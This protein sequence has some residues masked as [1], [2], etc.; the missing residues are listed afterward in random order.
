MFKRLL[1][2]NRGE[3]ACRIIKTAKK[4][5]ITT[6]AIYSDVDSKSLYVTEADEAFHIGPAPAID[7]YLNIN[8]IITLAKNI[9][10]DAIHPGYGF[11]SENAEFAKACEDANIIFVGP[12]SKNIHDMGLKNEAK[13]LAAKYG[14]PVLSDDKTFPLLIKPVAG[15]GGKGMR[16]VWQEKDFAE[17]L[18]SA[19]RE[20]LN[21]FGNDEV[22]I[23][24]YL[25]QPRHIE[26]QV[27]ADKHQNAV[28]LFER[29]CSLQ[30]RYQ[31]VIEQAPA[32]QLSQSLREKMGEAA[33]NIVRGINYIGLGTFEFLLDGNEKFYFMEMNT[34][35][36]VEHGVTELITGIDLVEQQLYVAAGEKLSLKQNDLKMS[37]VAIEARIYAEDPSEDFLPSTGEILYLEYPENVRFDNGIK[38][39]DKITIYYD[40]LLAK[41]LVHADNHKNAWQALSNALKQTHIAGLKTNLNFLR[42]CAENPH[43]TEHPV[44]THYIDTHPELCKPKPITDI[45]IILAAL[46][47]ITHEN[48]KIHSISPWQFNNAWR[49]NT[50]SIQKI[51][52]NHANQSY[53]LAIEFNNSSYTIFYQNHDYKINPV[54]LD[55]NALTAEI[56]NQEYHR[57]IILQKNNIWLLGE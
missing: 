57:I 5:N 31:K 27:L 30:R 55:H 40:P 26:I 52:L 39:G 33:L 23:E 19:K 22:I 18:A 11:L 20:A 21:S 15:G 2:A 56:N 13:K 4:L 17:N 32:M 8:K 3:I 9:K 7:S 16:I 54:Q 34:R 44:D 36:Q 6:I 14:C 43:I 42:A 45:D 48:K 37:G 46:G 50:P 12:S 38:I 29:D 1:I 25:T 35:L 28:Y 10:A 53:E 51:I 49:L 24:K 47:F 41:L